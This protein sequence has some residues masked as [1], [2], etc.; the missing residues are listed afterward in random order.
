MRINIKKMLGPRG[1]GLYDFVAQPELTAKWGGAFNGQEFRRAIFD[2][3]C[4][5]ISFKAIIETGTYRGNTTAYMAKAKIPIYTVEF[6][7]RNHSYVFIRF[8]FNSKVHVANN[9]SRA[10]LNDLALKIDVPKEKVFFYLDAHWN[11]DLPLR[12]E[13]EIIFSTW[14]DS[15]VMIDD[16]EVPGTGYAFDDYG[17]GNVLNLQYLRKTRYFD[18][19][20]IYFPAKDENSETGQKR[21]CVVLTNSRKCAEVLNQSNTLV[22]WKT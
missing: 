14:R 15:I 20:K 21:G 17:A 5:S 13:L 1:L 22:G 18:D 3:L 6:N 4:E 10:F 7:A 11:A 19:Y 2:E 9:D 16:F 12:K 8:I